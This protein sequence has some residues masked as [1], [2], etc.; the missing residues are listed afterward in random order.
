MQ[1]LQ[2]ILQTIGTARTRIRRAAA[3]ARTRIE[4]ISAEE[5]DRRVAAGA[6]LIDVRYEKEFRAGHIPGAI[7]IGWEVLATDIGRIVSDRE[8]P[9]VCYCT[10]GQ[11][12]AIAADTL[13]QLGYRAAA[14]V[15]GGIHA[16]LAYSPQP[17]IARIPETRRE[18]SSP[19]PAAKPGRTRESLLTSL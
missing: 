6:V 9:I 8:T 10:F 19:V 1:R 13:R 7:R 15:E 3:E 11:R 18:Q 2:S 12:S 17:K 4:E 16:Y 5:A 14:S